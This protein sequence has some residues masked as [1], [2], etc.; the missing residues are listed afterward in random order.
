MNNIWSDTRKLLIVIPYKDENH[1]KSFRTALD[2]LLN[3]SN[4]RELNIIVVIP[5]SVILPSESRIM[6][7]EYPSGH[8]SGS[9]PSGSGRMIRYEM[10]P[11]RLLHQ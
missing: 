3:N 6:N 2:Q 7:H 8:F 1:F 4:V 11:S 5:D 9:V 10:S